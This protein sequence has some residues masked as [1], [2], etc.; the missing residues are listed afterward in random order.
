MRSKNSR[1]DDPEI[2]IPGDHFNINP[3]S[4]VAGV[5]M[6]SAEAFGWIHRVL[7]V[8]SITLVFCGFTEDSPIG[9]ALRSM[10]VLG[11]G[12]VELLQWD[13]Q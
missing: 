8:K 4:L 9:K 7:A 2:I 6:L 13:L 10:E 11:V 12:R 3:L 1:V 5:D